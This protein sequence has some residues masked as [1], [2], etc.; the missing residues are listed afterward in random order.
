MRLLSKNLWD[1]TLIDSD[2]KKVGGIIIETFNEQSLIVGVGLNL[3]PV[4]EKP[5]FSYE[6]GFILKN[7]RFETSKLLE[8]IYSYKVGN[9]VQSWSALC[10]HLNEEVS[11]ESDGKE[12]NVKFVG[13]GEQ[14]EALFE[15]ASPQFSGSIRLK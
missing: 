14:G 13:I 7:E 9:V 5:K 3:F 10:C 12:S 1:R 4:D 15:D 11:F 6:T 8:F 2:R